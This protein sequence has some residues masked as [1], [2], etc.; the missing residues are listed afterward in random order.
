M[1]L[2]TTTGDEEARCLANDAI[3]VRSALYSWCSTISGV[4]YI[5]R[6]LSEV[7][8]ITSFLV[9]RCLWCC[10]GLRILGNN[11]SA[12]RHCS[13]LFRF[14]AY[15]AASW[16][17]VQYQKLGETPSRVAPHGVLYL[18]DHKRAHVTLKNATSRVT[19]LAGLHYT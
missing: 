18:I 10:L 12:T 3:A 4:I 7:Q 13:C 6:V 5:E 11:Y 9:T 19:W 14:K 16:L 1:Y 8:G 15:L 17:Q 2:T